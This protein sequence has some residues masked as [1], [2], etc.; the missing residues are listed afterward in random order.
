MILLKEGKMKKWYFLF[1]V[2]CSVLTPVVAEGILDGSGSPPPTHYVFVKE[3][4]SDDWEGF[5]SAVREHAVKFKYIFVRSE[6]TDVYEEN[7]LNCVG[8]T[9]YYYNDGTN[10][11]FVLRNDD[12]WYLGTVR[13]FNGTQAD[14]AISYFKEQLP[15]VLRDLLPWL[16]L[17]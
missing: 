5:Y 12:P 9:F 11:Q 10:Y 15:N 3:D 1:S 8:N 2:F 16:L 14:A 6:S 17:F 13:R 4:G 7:A